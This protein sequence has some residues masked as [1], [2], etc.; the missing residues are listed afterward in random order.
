[1]CFMLFFITSIHQF[2]FNIL[3][4]IYS[5]SSDLSFASSLVPCISV[6]LEK[7]IKSWLLIFL[8]HSVVHAGVVDAMRILTA[9]VVSVHLLVTVVS[10]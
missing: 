1:M 9:C 7:A 8:P 4:W 3:L 10:C 5:W 6:S 2:K